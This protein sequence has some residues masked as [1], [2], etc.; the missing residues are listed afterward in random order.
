M[1]W[2]NIEILYCWKNLACVLLFCAFETV[3]HNNIQVW[4]LQRI[5][6]NISL[7]YIDLFPLSTFISWNMLGFFC[8][9]L[10]PCQQCPMFLP[11]KGKMIRQRVK[12][13]VLY[14]PELNANRAIRKIQM[15]YKYCVKNMFHSSGWNTVKVIK[16]NVVE[17]LCCSLRFIKRL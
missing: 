2:R 8:H 4:H 6:H 14:V 7:I 15:K 17:R 3:F 12:H 11:W 1:L 16:T 13:S 9:K 10:A 5:Y